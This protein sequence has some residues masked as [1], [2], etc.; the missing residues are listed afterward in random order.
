MVVLADLLLLFKSE[1]YRGRTNFTYSFGEFGADLCPSW[2]LCRRKVEK[3]KTL[4]LN[5]H[6][7]QFLFQNF[8][9][10]GCVSISVQEMALAFHSAG[11][12][13]TVD[14]TFKGAQ[15]VAL[16]KFASTWQ[17]DNFDTW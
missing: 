6:K 8:D 7:A 10:V 9:P 4:S 16:V 17:A 14:P 11:G 3:F 1:S 5:V 13:D 12:K 2:T 15:Y